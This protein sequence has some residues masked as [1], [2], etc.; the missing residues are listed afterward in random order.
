[1]DRNF[2]EHRENGFYL[3]GSRV[4]IDRIVR[5]YRNGEQPEAIRSHYSALSLEQ[6]HGAI[7]FYLGHKDEVEKVMAERERV[8]DEFSKTHPA[9]PQLKAKLE[10]ARQQL[11]ARR[12]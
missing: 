10:R 3:V 11:L 4:P 9:P 12:S 1:M 8:Q 7:A 6:V 5:E 2:L